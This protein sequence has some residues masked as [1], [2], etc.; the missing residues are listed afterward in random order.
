MTTRL[1]VAAIAATASLA[2]CGTDDPG[3]GKS[4][5]ANDQSN[6]R[7]VMLEYARCMREHG[8][9]MP[10]PEF[11]GNRTKMMGPADADPTKMRAADKACGKIRDSLKP[12]EISDEDKEAFKKAALANA[13]CM[14]EHGIPEFPDPTFDENGGAQIQMRRGG[15][16]D[17]ESPKFKTAEKACRSTLPFG[18]KTD[19]EKP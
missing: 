8:I 6:A 4:P 1:L 18:G 10:D 3:T 12:P 16:V 2:A 17:P 9:D 11:E 13:R 15:A 5:G 14:R 7:K 19:A